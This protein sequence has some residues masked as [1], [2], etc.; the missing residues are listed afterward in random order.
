[1]LS[2]LRDITKNGPTS[3]HGQELTVRQ[4]GKEQDWEV[5]NKEGWE[6][7]MQM[8]DLSEEHSVMRFE[9]LCGSSQ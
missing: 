8:M 4:D 7:D 5:S 9:Y 2:G 6:R 1:M 3:I